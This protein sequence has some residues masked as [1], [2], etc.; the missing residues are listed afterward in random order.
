MNIN[1]LTKRKKITTRQRDLY[2]I[3]YFRSNIL[4]CNIIIP[5]ELNI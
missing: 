1:N 4:K 2:I 3:F 5:I